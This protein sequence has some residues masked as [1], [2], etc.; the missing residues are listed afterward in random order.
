MKP[1]EI[2]SYHDALMDE[3]EKYTYD[4]LTYPKRPGGPL[5]HEDARRMAQ[6]ERARHEKMTPLR[7][8]VMTNYQPQKSPVNSQMYI[9]RLKTTPPRI[10]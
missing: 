4:I 8:F 7:K 5:A 3:V 6:K 1:S 10:N 2:D 9:F